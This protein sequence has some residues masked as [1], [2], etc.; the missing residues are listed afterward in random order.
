MHRIWLILPTLLLAAGCGGTSGSKS[1]D[2]QVAAPVASQTLQVSEK[3]FSITPAS[4]TVKKP[5]TYAFH[6]SNDGS[7]SHALVVEGQGNETKTG[8]IAPGSST[9]LSVT[10]SKAGK[11]ELYC[12]ID[13]HQGKGMKATL[14]V[15]G[16]ASS[17][18]M[19]GT[20]PAPTQTGEGTTTDDKGGYG[21]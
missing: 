18:G 1:S 14:T 16:A 7:I 2:G 15:Q 8:T 9:T 17:A 19:N 20:S 5:A 10:L 3:E 11:Y 12:P 13:G 6:V 4:I 21:Y